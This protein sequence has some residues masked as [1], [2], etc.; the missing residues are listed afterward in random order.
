[1]IRVVIV[2]VL[3]GLIL[4]G[5]GWAFRWLVQNRVR[6]T[7]HRAP[8]GREVLWISLVLQALRSLLRL[9]FRI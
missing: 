2:L 7:M 5:A 6:I 8:T 1:M 4:L 3:L 9:L